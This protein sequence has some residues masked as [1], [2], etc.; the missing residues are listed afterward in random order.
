M[1]DYLSQLEERDRQRRLE[2][3]Q[4]KEEQERRL[5]DPKV[6]AEVERSR[7]FDKLA[8]ETMLNCVKYAERVKEL[9]RADT[10]EID[11]DRNNTPYSI[12]SYLKVRH[13]YVGRDDRKFEIRFERGK[14]RFD[15]T[16]ESYTDHWVS[17]RT[18]YE[19][20]VCFQV[21]ELNEN[22]MGTLMQWVLRESDIYSEN[23][24]PH[25]VGCTVAFL[26]V[27]SA[28]YLAFNSIWHWLKT[29]I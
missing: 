8:R 12:P 5:R 18:P 26:L 11:W 6:I 25:R 28:I 16:C 17:E 23:T 2:M 3:L 21:N 1:P 10:I 24:V 4:Q 14:K 13:Y 15:V 19:K 27:A 29:I 9:Q 22:A 20:Q 7:A